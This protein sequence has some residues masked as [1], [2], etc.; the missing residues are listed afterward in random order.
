MKYTLRKLTENTITVEADNER[1]AIEIAEDSD[2]WNAYDLH[3]IEVKKKFPYKSFCDSKG[4]YVAGCV[5]CM[6]D[7]KE[8]SEN[9]YD[10]SFMGFHFE[11]K[12]GTNYMFFKDNDKDEY[13]LVPMNRKECS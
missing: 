3:D 1:E 10:L 4:C 5:I 2:N 7:L 13:Y 6:E 11:T 9:C 12:T 8:M